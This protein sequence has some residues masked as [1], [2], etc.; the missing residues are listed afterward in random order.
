MI[1]KENVIELAETSKIIKYSET[2][3]LQYNLPENILRILKE[4]GVPESVSPY[5]IFKEEEKGGLSKLSAYYDLS[6]YEQSDEIE[7]EELDEIKIYFQN[8]IVLGNIENDVFVL[9]EKFQ[10]IRVDYETLDEYYVN[11]T[12]D[13]FLESLLTYKRTIDEVKSRY[14]ENVYFDEYITRDDITKLKE[15]LIK[16][17]RYALDEDSFWSY[18]IESLEENI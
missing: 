7:K 3:C 6:L 8:Y 1:S 2:L 12:L 14:N 9:N 13:I 18:E 4:I 17:D 5:V 10:I 15:N 16:L 11:Y